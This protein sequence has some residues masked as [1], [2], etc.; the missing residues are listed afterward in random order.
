MKVLHGNLG[1]KLNHI[2]QPFHLTPREKDIWELHEKG[3]SRKEICEALG[4]K[5]SS[6]DARFL[7]IKEKVAARELKV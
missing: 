2:P 6:I 1:K 3:M 7:V 5:R 4:L